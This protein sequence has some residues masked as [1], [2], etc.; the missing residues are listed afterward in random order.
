MLQRGSLADGLKSVS[1]DNKS[2]NDDVRSQLKDMASNVGE[3]GMS[4]DEYKNQ[5][6]SVIDSKLKGMQDKTAKKMGE[7]LASYLNNMEDMTGD[8][9]VPPFQVGQTKP[10]FDA[11]NKLGDIGPGGVQGLV[12]T[13][14]AALFPINFQLSTPPPGSVQKVSSIGSPVPMQPLTPV[15]TGP[16]TLDGFHN[17]FATIVHAT[18]STIPIV[19]NH[20]IPSPSGPVPGPPIPGVAK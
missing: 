14:W 7:E 17:Q 12:Q 3:D 11:I 5:S 9:P 20:L 18:A 4:Y 10:I 8:N 6:Q 13:H 15:L 2:T 16:G 19:I 1:S